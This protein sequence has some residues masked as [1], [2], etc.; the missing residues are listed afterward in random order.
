MELLNEGEE[1]ELAWGTLC[2][3]IFLEHTKMQEQKIFNGT[4]F[5]LY[6]IFQQKSHLLRTS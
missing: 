2:G 4:F 3:W 1:E 5:F 6:G